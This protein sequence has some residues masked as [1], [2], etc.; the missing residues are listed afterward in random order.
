ML[1]AMGTVAGVRL[2]RGRLLG[3]PLKA[4]LAG[5]RGVWMARGCDLC[6]PGRKAVVFVTGLCDDSCF[7]CPVSRGK[8]GRDVFYVNEVPVASVEE[9]VAE[10]L[11]TG[12]SGASLTG[13]DPLVALHRTLEVARALKS[14]LGRGFHI[15]LY[16]SGRRMTPEV[17]RALW[18][19]GVDEVRIHPT[20]RSL[21]SRVGMVKRYTGMSVGVEMPIAPGLE[22]L[23]IEAVKTVEA[24]GGDFVNLNEMEIVEPNARALLARGYTESGERPFTV[25]GALE[26]ALRVLEWAAENSSVPVH[27]CPASFKDSIQTGNRLRSSAARDAYWYEEPTPHGTLTWGEVRGGSPPPGLGEERGGRIMLPPREDLLETVVRMYGGEAYIVEAHPTPSRTPIV[28][29]R[30]IA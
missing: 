16:T 25:R 3:D 11:R 1:G 18:E 23:A 19:A 13:G 9:A 4:L 17:A 15:H 26:A 22:E 5:S 27:F 14:E 30:R 7:Y 24:V 28:S 12:A 2:R 6:F 20:E 21:L 10:V 8:L 29:E